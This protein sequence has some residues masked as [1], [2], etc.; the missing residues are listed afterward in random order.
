MKKLIVV[1]YA[2]GVLLASAMSRAEEFQSL[3]VTSAVFDSKKKVIVVRGYLPSPCVR[4]LYPVFDD[5]QGGVIQIGVW[6][7]NVNAMCMTVLGGTF[8]MKI[9]LDSIGESVEVVDPVVALHVVNS[10]LFFEVERPLLMPAVSTPVPTPFKMKLSKD[11]SLTPVSL[12][13]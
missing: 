13:N 2:L 6:S 5:S 7:D 9:P 1:A 11:L 8:E 10:D 4:G 12:G 3:P